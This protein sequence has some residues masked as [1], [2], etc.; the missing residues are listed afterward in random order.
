[1]ET[2]DL[3]QV[4]V[5]DRITNELH[6]QLDKLAGMQKYVNDKISRFKY[7]EQDGSDKDKASVSKIAIDFETQSMYERLKILSDQVRACTVREGRILQML[8]EL[9]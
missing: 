2:K 4:P 7:F 3:K 5:I 8:N 1:M 9:V 6:E